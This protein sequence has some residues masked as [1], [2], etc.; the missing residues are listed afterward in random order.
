MDYSNELPHNKN[1]Q[2]IYINN[3]DIPYFIF[4]HLNIDKHVY[5]VKE[6]RTV[7]SSIEGEETELLWDAIS[8]VM[9]LFC[10]LIKLSIIKV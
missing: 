7:V 9:K 10:T 4:F 8:E 3:M 1:N 5:T 6:I 2:T